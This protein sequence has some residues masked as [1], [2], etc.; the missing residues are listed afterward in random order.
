MPCNNHR[1]TVNYL[2]FQA[3]WHLEVSAIKLTI[4]R[5]KPPASGLKQVDITALWRV[6]LSINCIIKPKAVNGAVW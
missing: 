6:T 5:T 2:H 3:V 4:N 1:D